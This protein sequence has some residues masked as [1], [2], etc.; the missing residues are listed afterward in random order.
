LAISTEKPKA[1]MV[2]GREVVN[3]LHI[4]TRKTNPIV[5]E[6]ADKKEECV[7]EM[8]TL[9]IRIN[10]YY[11]AIDFYVADIG[12]EIIL[13]LPFIK[14]IQVTNQTWSEQRYEFIDLN[15]DKFHQWFGAGIENNGNKSISFSDFVFSF[16]Q[17]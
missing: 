9:K 1:T 15:T 8:I 4:K 13:G 5:L 11:R 16:F 3:S 7:D 12:N 6:Y 17:A 2:V 14:T 10:D